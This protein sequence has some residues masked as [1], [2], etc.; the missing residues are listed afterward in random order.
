MID[1]KIYKNLSYPVKRSHLRNYVTEEI[2]ISQI[3]DTVADEICNT[4]GTTSLDDWNIVKK[5]LID[6]CI[7]YEVIHSENDQIVE[8]KELDA[9]TILPA[10]DSE[11]KKVWVQELGDSR[12]V[13]LGSQVLYAAYSNVNEN[14]SYVESILRP[15]NLMKFAEDSAIAS[16]ISSGQTN[17]AAKDVSYFRNYFRNRFL[18][19]TR[20]P[21]AYFQK[22]DVNLFETPEVESKYTDKWDRFVTR[23]AKNLESIIK[24]S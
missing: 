16:G 22:S 7:S 10:I 21:T 8:K 12:R 11:G 3:V 13:L 5:Y 9:A 20:I 24:H 15:Y 4:L 2:E 19:S 23:H 6:G 14:I 1:F 18:V 17:L